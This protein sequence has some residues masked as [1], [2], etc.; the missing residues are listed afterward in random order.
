MI[1]VQV[2]AEEQHVPEG[3]TLDS[4]LAQLGKT[5]SGIAVAVDGDVVGRGEWNSVVLSD[6]A[7]VEI[8]TAVQGG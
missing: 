6:G 4:L 5:H 1:A 8:L 2:N 3:T 7:R